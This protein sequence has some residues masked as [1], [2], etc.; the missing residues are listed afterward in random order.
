MSSP[1]LPEAACVEHEPEAI[2]KSAPGHPRGI[3][4]GLCKPADIACIGITNQRE[5][6]LLW[7]AGQSRSAG[8]SFGNADAPPLVSRF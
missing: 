6:A 3:P 1:D 4:Q 5:T 7:D 8:P 2:W